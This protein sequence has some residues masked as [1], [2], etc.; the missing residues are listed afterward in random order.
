MTRFQHFSIRVT[1]SF[2]SLALCGI[3][4][5]IL[6]S[7][8]TQ[9]Q[10]KTAITSDS[11]LGTQVTQNGSIHDITRGTRP[12]D[13]PNLFHSF[14]QFSVG[15]SATANFLNNTGAPTTN[16]L[17]RVTGGQ[18]S[19]IFG[20]IQTTGFPGANLFLVNPTGMVFGP[21]A[22]LN[23]SGAA[24]FT[25]ADSLRLAD[26]VQFNAMP[27]PSDAQLTSA[28]VEAFGFL[29]ENPAGITVDRSSLKVP[30]G[31]TL[32]LV[33]G[34]ISIA[35][36]RDQPPDETRPNLAAEGGRVNLVSVGFG[37]GSG[38]QHPRCQC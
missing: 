16:I 14:G 23:V 1:P 37:G 38:T 28:P 6:A 36:N 32:S 31:E 7:S 15:A 17:G 2:N 27:G 20:T 35:G 3:L 8:I 5:H 13:G 29:N 22:T 9:A 33:G 21:N 12:G 30:D 4:L 11:T 26:G 25:T 34:N 19:N 10:V 18:V 24:H